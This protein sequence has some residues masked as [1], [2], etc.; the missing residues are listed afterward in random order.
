MLKSPGA[1]KVDRNTPSRLMLKK[2]ELSAGPMGHSGLYK[3]FTFFT[4]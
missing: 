2:P 4:E 1:L 3:D